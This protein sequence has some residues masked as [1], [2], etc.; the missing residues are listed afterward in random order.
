M[1]K[2]GKEVDPPLRKKG[3]K[4]SANTGRDV[5]FLSLVTDSLLQKKGKKR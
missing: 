3:K 2:K 1:R 4:A 5:V